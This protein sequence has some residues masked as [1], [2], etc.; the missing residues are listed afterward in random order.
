MSPWAPAMD[1]AFVP[2]RCSGSAA[3]RARRRVAD[4]LRGYGIGARTSA[5]AAWQ[6][7]EAKAKEEAEAKAKEQ[8][9]ARAKQEA[10]AEAKAKEQNEA[11]AK[12]EAEDDAKEKAKRKAAA[13]PSGASGGDTEHST[14]CPGPPSA[15]A[16]KTERKVNTDAAN[17]ILWRSWWRRDEEDAERQRKAKLET[18]RKAKSQPKQRH[19]GIVSW[20]QQ[21]GVR[22]YEA[23]SVPELVHMLEV[24]GD[25]LDAPALARALEE[26]MVDGRVERNSAGLFQ[27]T[28][29]SWAHA[30]LDHA[31]C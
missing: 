12:Q 8:D 30:M 19:D 28:N 7:F 21:F 9:E 4:F 6:E 22:G 10:G 11:R 1:M 24:V 18:E 3:R 14:Q 23:L 2:Q 5:C 16:A 26:L 29:S 27:L 20:L 15:P 31:L 25:P 13:G 17:V